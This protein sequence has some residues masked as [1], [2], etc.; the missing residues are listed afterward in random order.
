MKLLFGKIEGYKLIKFSS[1][2][3]RTDQR[4][5]CARDL[6]K[7]RHTVDTIVDTKVKELY[8]NYGQLVN[9]NYLYH[10]LLKKILKI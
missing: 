10:D 1:R 2:R 5:L 6:D 7:L 8:E 9:E 4:M 3:K